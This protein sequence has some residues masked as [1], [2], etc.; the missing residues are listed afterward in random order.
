MHPIDLLAGTTDGV[1]L[2]AP[3]REYTR[4]EFL[5]TVWKTGNFFRTLG[6]HEGSLVAITAHP[7]PESLLSF[8]GASLLDARVRFNPPAS[9]DARVVVGPTG[10]LDEFE[11]PAGGQFV[12]YGDDPADPSWAYFEREVWSENPAFPDVD[13]PPD[14]PLIE[15]EQEQFHAEA[16]VGA[17]GTIAGDLSTDD[18]VAVRSPLSTPGTIVAGVLAPLAADATI[19]LP[20]ETAT[21][22]VAVTD[23]EAPEPRTIDPERVALRGLAKDGTDS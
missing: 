9:I 2:E 4:R 7:T 22:S 12:G 18:V 19:L 20:D 16:V 21:G 10:A 11:L 3:P 6:V 14:A 8:L 17:A 5:N 23:V 13:H 1:V 15:T